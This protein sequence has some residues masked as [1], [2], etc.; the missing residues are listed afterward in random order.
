MEGMHSMNVREDRNGL[1]ILGRDECLMLLAGAVVGR[2][3]ASLGST[4]V[5]L[6]VNFR[7]VGEQILFETGRGTKL[8][9]ATRNAAVSFEIDD[10]DRFSHTGWSVV[11]AGVAREVTDPA[12]VAEL[13]AAKIP[14]WA[15][16]GGHRIV[17]IDISKLSGRRI[18]QRHACQ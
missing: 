1:E 13:R 6:P 18:P 16:E 2:I 3:G 11:A 4:P 17:A 7:L 10:F 8:D 9:A 12:M 15:P 5:V 14:R